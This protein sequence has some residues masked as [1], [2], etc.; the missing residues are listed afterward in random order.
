MNRVREDDPFK[1]D[2]SFLCP[3]EDGDPNDDYCDCQNYYHAWCDT[4]DKLD[5]TLKALAKLKKKTIRK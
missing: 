3:L 4:K 1:N 2:H 5:A